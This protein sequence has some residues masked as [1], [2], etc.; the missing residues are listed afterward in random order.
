MKLSAG[1]DARVAPGP[2]HP[3]DDTG[4]CLW[5]LQCLLLGF[6]GHGRGAHIHP[7]RL[8]AGGKGS[9]HL[10]MLVS[11]QAHVHCLQPS[12]GPR[13]LANLLLAKRK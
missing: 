7:G 9:C 2:T 6:S 11:F 13:G 5:H 1:L 8:N 4:S 12:Q 10:G 3:Q